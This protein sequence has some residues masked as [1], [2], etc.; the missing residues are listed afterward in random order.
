[1]FLDLMMPGMDGFETLAKIRE[2]DAELPVYAL[3]ADASKGEAFYQSC[4]FT[5]FLVKPVRSEMLERIIMKHLRRE[6]MDQPREEK[7]EGT[8]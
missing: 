7:E 8:H 5:G 4:G 2:F 6:M 1:V 3:A